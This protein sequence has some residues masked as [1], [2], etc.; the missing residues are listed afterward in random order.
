MDKDGYKLI[1]EILDKS[2]R[3]DGG[4]DVAITPPVEALGEDVDGDSVRFV[5]LSFDTGTPIADILNT[6]DK[7]KVLETRART[8]T[9][10]GPLLRAVPGAIT[11]D[12]YL[13]LTFEDLNDGVPS[14]TP[15]A[16]IAAAVDPVSADAWLSGDAGVV[17]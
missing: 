11:M 17:V 14:A 2:R 10:A 3:P 9:A 6:L 4:L 13:T 12:G 15:P 16:E 8:A 1:T 7:G 5:D